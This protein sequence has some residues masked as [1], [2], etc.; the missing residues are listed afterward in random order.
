[1]ARVCL[2]KAAAS[3][4]PCLDYV[5]SRPALGRVAPAFVSGFRLEQRFSVAVSSDSPGSLFPSDRGGEPGEVRS[6]GRHYDARLFPTSSGLVKALT[7][8]LLPRPYPMVSYILAV[9]VCGTAIGLTIL[10]RRIS[11]LKSA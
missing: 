3:L 9:F 1:M 2:A 11:T 4:R 8:D 10:A 5:H 7:H 6:A